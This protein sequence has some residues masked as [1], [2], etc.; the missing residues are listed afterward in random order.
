MN[1]VADLG[2]SFVKSGIF[3]DDRGQIF[4]KYSLV[5]HASEGLEQIF[6]GFL[7]FPLFCVVFDRPVDQIFHEAYDVF[8]VLLEK[9]EVERGTVSFTQQLV[10]SDENDAVFNNL[11]IDFSREEF[12]ESSQ[13]FLEI[14]FIQQLTHANTFLE[15][16]ASLFQGGFEKR[17]AEIFE[18][19]DIVQNDEVV[20][21]VFLKLLLFRL[22]LSSDFTEG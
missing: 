11:L 17:D 22:Q 19:V 9:A 13:I 7:L 18:F 3:P 20:D 12:P 2:E 21:D 14:F 16:L 8:P 15:Q 4:G 10:I 6:G 5:G 1:L